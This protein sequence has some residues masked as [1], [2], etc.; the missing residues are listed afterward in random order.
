VERDFDV[1][2]GER[3]GFLV[4]KSA[5]LADW[6]FR[7]EDKEFKK[8]CTR[9]YARN[10]ARRERAR[11][12]ERVQARQRA[13]RSANRDH[14][15]A[16]DRALKALKRKPKFIVCWTCNAPHQVKKLTTA[17]H[18]VKFCSRK[19]ANRY[20]GVPRARARNRGIRTMTIIPQILDV[21]ASAP[22][23][24][25]LRM[26]VERLPGCKRGSIATT[27]VALR[28]AGRVVSLGMYHG[29]GKGNF[30]NLYALPGPPHDALR[31]PEGLSDR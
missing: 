1:D 18:V 9:L 2:Y 27:I 25:N 8:L 28:K 31:V 3:A 11:H 7:K 26:L 30:G 22:T 20:H 23:G 10:W 5:A 4:G 17:G 16:L 6:S 19:C 21:L 14:V 15:R 24:L 29:K 13:W 12:P